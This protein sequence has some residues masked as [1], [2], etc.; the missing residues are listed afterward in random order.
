MGEWGYACVCVCVRERE[1]ER[2]RVY[3]FAGLAWP[4]RARTDTL[5]VALPPSLHFLAASLQASSDRAGL[6]S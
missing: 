4:G 5:S 3:L 2:E 6:V 1:R